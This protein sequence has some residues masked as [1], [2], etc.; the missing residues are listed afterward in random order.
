MFE[1]MISGSSVR[2]FLFL[3]ASLLMSTAL[4]ADS[5]TVRYKEGV[6]HGF[7]TLAPESEV[8]YQMSEF[9]EPVA[10]RGVRWNDAAFAISWPPD[11]RVM[12]ERDQNYADFAG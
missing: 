9:Y 10:A 7:Q 2:L 1:R 5:V 11:E 4:G 8:F 3:T 12:N 6:A